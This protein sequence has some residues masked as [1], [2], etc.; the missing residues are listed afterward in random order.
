MG[1][2]Q[3]KLADWVLVVITV[4]V[5]F[6]ALYAP[7]L[8]DVGVD[9]IP[10][11]DKIGH[12]IIFALATWALLRVFDLR[13]VM[14][15]MVVQLVVSEVVQGLFLPGRSGDIGDAIA[16]AVGIAVGWWT[17]RTATLQDGDGNTR[18]GSG[19]EA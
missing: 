4:G 8:P 19:P 9:G 11:V 13:L 1:E 12:I 7:S 15:L 5:Q 6:W 3:R 17:W 10:F 18:T 2:Q 16:D 14:A